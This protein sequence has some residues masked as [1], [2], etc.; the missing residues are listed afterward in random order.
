MSSKLLFSLYE[1]L[2][3]EISPCYHPLVTQMSEIEILRAIDPGLAKAKRKNIKTLATLSLFLSNLP[4]QTSPADLYISLAGQIS[5]YKHVDLSQQS[6]TATILLDSREAAV[7][8]VK[9]YHKWATADMKVQ[10]THC[11]LIVENFSNEVFAGDNGESGETETGDED[12]ESA[13]YSGQIKTVVALDVDGCRDV[14]S[15]LLGTNSPVLVDFS[16]YS[17]EGEE[18]LGAELYLGTMPS[19]K[20]VLSHR[21][22]TSGHL[23]SLF[24]GDSVKIVNRMDSEAVQ[25]AISFLF[26]NDVNVRNVFDLSMAVRS[27]DFFEYGQSWFQQPM[28]SSR[29]IGKLLGLSLDPK[30]SK[31]HKSYLAYLQLKR[32]IPT[33]IQSLLDTFVELDIISAAQTTESLKAKAKKSEMK[34]VLENKYVHIRLQGKS[35]LQFKTDSRVKLKEL[36]YSY[37]DVVTSLTNEEEKSGIIRDYSEFGRS[38]LVETSSIHR[39]AQL[40][41]F[42]E[43]QQSRTDLKYI[44]SN[45]SFKKTL[46]KPKTTTNLGTLELSLRENIKN[47]ANAGL[48]ISYPEDSC[49]PY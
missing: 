6:R 2:Q 16:L 21:M 19:Y 48:Q 35:G 13:I 46:E 37:N 18:R 20:L 1:T 40:V 11:Q 36:V 5:G 14:V 38:V 7:T 31:Q 4:P 23:A 3:R 33:K 44:V 39:V 25:S 24:S 26:K 34:Q 22:L 17:S 12:V 28:P 42:L 27:L 45:T 41:H 9:E 30:T 29:N 15:A 43:Q 8:A 47:L 10:H 49:L 32:K